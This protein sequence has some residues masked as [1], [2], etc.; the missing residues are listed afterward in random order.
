MAVGV[1]GYKSS[2]GIQVTLR[3]TM[4]MD[5]LLA[6]VPT[7]KYNCDFNSSTSRDNGEFVVIW[8]SNMVVTWGNAVLW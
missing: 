2:V 1:D 3:S 7:E 6:N 5:G 4:T 8:G